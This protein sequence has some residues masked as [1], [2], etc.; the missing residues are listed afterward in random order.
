VR[1]SPNQVFMQKKRLEK[2]PGKLEN[3]RKTE[4][5]FFYGYGW[6]DLANGKT[7]LKTK[8]NSGKTESAFC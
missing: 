8:N 1:D 5:A 7:K 6:N 4:S 2:L 3:S